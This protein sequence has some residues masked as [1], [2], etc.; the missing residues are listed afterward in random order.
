[1]TDAK[2]SVLFNNLVKAVQHWLLMFFRPSF[3]FE[4]SPKRRL[5]FTPMKC[6]YALLDQHFIPVLFP[7]CPLPKSAEIA[8]DRDIRF[9]ARTTGITVEPKQSHVSIGAPIQ[10]A[11]NFCEHVHRR[12]RGGK[13]GSSDCD[14]SQ[15]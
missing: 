12:P 15:F 1:M 14:C 8:T 11:P 4:L 2:E 5:H 6:V 3:P 7:I 9:V 10:T 13:S